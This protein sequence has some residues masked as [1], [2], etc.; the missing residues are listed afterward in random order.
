[1]K[2]LLLLSALAVAAAPAW[3]VTISPETALARALSSA[4][5]L[6]A[7][8]AQSH[9]WELAYTAP[10]PEHEEKAGCYLFKSANGFLIAS[11]DDRARGLLAYGDDNGFDV[12]TMSPEMK[13]W[14]EEYGREMYA[15]K[16]EPWGEGDQDAITDPKDPIAPLCATHW[17][18]MSPYDE[19]CSEAY[20][21][22][23]VTG[24]VATAM[25]QVMKYHNWPPQGKG[26]HTYRSEGKEF[27]CDFGSIIFDWKNMT[28]NYGRYSTKAERHAVAELMYACGVSVG[29]HY[30]PGGSGADPACVSPGLIAYFDYDESG[31]MA[32]RRYY[33]LQE[34]NDLIYTQL[35]E[36]GPVQYSGFTAGGGGHSFVCDGYAKGGYYHI[37]WG[38]GGANDGFFQLTALKANHLREDRSE[39]QGGFNFNQ[40]VNVNIRPAKAG[41]P[42]KPA[43]VVVG[44]GRFHI[45]QKV[46]RAAGRVTVL[47]DFWN[48]GVRPLD[49]ELTLMAVSQTEPADTVWLKGFTHTDYRA[50]E[51]LYAY[52]V[53]MSWDLKPGEYRMYPI[54][55]NNADDQ[56]YPIH[57]TVDSPNYVDAK[58]W[59]K[60][61]HRFIGFSTD[62]DAAITATDVSSTEVIEKD[63]GFE[64]RATLGNTS[65]FE[66]MG[67]VA[68][69]IFDMHNE[70]IAY[71]Q[72]LE[73]D[74]PDGT[75]QD[76]LYTSRIDKIVRPDLF[77]SGPAQMYVIDFYSHK[78]VG[79]PALVTI[80]APADLGVQG[81]DVTTGPEGPVTVWTMQGMRVASGE[82]S[83]L[84][85]AI[86]PGIYIVRDAAGHAAKRI[87]R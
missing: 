68:A 85:T 22:P 60:D 33:G 59:D 65:G 76:I 56:W 81:I 20:G 18:Q 45:A 16:D 74:L 61:G 1:M 17:N 70:L 46:S 48:A 50:G 58:V 87:V 6:N 38:W 82:W 35:K 13:W 12:K 63:K 34:W 52:E 23:V 57:I 25:A 62:Y 19:V 40:M 54:F 42:G 30:H 71:G 5:H 64:M 55:R 2:K 28:D 47:S 69:G 29:M 78:P 4:V 31:Y 37:N 86:A 77:V 36:Y 84:S 26:E 24:C 83:E 73:V 21:R 11:A 72:R 43:T 27:S 53:Q 49:G 14:L 79:A 9:D 3:G 66:W 7:R 41:E 75:E 8:V 51:G 67:P 44:A 39:G 10:V 15:A 80:D 32:Q